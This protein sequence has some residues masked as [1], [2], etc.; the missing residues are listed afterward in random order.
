MHTIS[1]LKARINNALN[2]E[3]AAHAALMRSC[4]IVE[5]LQASSDP[6]DPA[7]PLPPELDGGWTVNVRGDLATAPGVILDM[8]T[9]TGR[10]KVQYWCD[11]RSQWM[12]GAVDIERVTYAHHEIGQCL[13]C[14]AWD[15]YSAFDEDCRC[16]DC[17]PEPDEDEAPEMTAQDIA[18]MRADWDEL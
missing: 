16:V 17:Q 4:G 15:W 5:A 10:V 1:E 18:E 11:V 9:D 8:Y 3:A 2:E 14:G 12:T 7:P 6:G 13:S